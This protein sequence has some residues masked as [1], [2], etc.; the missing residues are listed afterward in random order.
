MDP[1]QIFDLYDF[2]RQIEVAAVRLALQ[3]ATDDQL[4]QFEE[5]VQQV[6][7][8]NASATSDCI[9]AADE[10]FQERLCALTG[11]IELQ[12]RLRNINDHLHYVHRMSSDV[13]QSEILIRH[14]EIAAAL[15]ERDTEKCLAMIADQKP[16]RLD[17]V[18]V[19]V[20]RCYSRLYM[21][22][23]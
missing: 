19:L 14:C 21:A 1:K 5:F 10:E 2:H 7:K 4:A 9:F 18:L 11:N 16:P 13:K 17:Q 6:A 23:H 3:R 15:L 22:D 8:E 12:S 20:E